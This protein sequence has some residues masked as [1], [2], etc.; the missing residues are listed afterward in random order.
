M[1]KTFL[2][3]RHRD[4]QCG[5]LIVRKRLRRNTSR[6]HL[7]EGVALCHI[8]H[9]C[10]PATPAHT[11]HY[12]NLENLPWH[13]PGGRQKG[14]RVKIR[15]KQVLQPF[16]SPV[17]AFVSDF[18]MSLP[19]DGIPPPP[20]FLFT[21]GPLFLTGT[22]FPVQL[23]SEE[24][25]FGSDCVDFSDLFREKYVIDSIILG[26]HG[27]WH[28]NTPERLRNLPVIFLHLDQQYRTLTDVS[29]SFCAFSE[30][31]VAIISLSFGQRIENADYK[32][33]F[34]PWSE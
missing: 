33:F 25:L 7:A 32:S 17:A 30:S 27:L 4:L 19:R 8:Q 9:T 16:S 12:K 15:Q 23:L 34:L 2:A 3:Q 28:R 18:F 21:I 29:V 11:W 26:K 22:C 14:T 24:V 31:R 13:W 5:W 20:F 1:V 10:T 6:G